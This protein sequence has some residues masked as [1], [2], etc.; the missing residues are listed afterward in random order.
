MSGNCFL[1]VGPQATIIGKAVQWAT[2]AFLGLLPTKGLDSKESPLLA[3]EE[4][5]MSK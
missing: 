3:V 2:I 4:L 1:L 5:G